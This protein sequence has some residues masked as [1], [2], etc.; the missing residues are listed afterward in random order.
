M[1]IA[2]ISD[3][4]IGDRVRGFP[5]RFLEKLAEFDAIVHCGDFTAPEVINQ[6]DGIAEFYGVYGNMDT[7]AIWQKLPESK[8]IEL[9]NYTI[10]ILHGWGSPYK[11]GQ[12]VLSW[13]QNNYP[14]INFDI[15]L[16]G[17]SH[18]PTDET[19][20]GV[21]VLNPG[22]IVGNAFSQYASW[23]SLELKN[24]EIIWS[25]KQIER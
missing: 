24:D 20:D 16:F 1:K 5:H 23:A 22:A 7:S 4:H 15:I 21:R 25:I 17:H 14:N 10:G 18:Q 9:Q 19:I 3:T 12:R 11:L 2:V 8:V 13:F 6:L